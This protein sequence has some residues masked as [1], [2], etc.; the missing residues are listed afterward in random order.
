MSCNNRIGYKLLKFGGLRAKQIRPHYA[1][2]N[3]LVIQAGFEPT[4]H[5]LEG[6][7]SIQLSYWTRK[8]CKGS[9]IFAIVQPVAPISFYEILQVL[10]PTLNANARNRAISDSR[11]LC[12]LWPTADKRKQMPA[13]KPPDSIRQASATDT[14]LFH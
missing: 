2:G 6:C 7:C 10:A 14:N 11:R 12:D 8:R 9:R 3:E 1:A 4:T 13:T 5:S